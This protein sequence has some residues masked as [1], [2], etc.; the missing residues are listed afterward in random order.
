MTNMNIAEQIG[1]PALLEQAAEE[2]AELVVACLKLSRKMRNENPTPKPMEECVSNLCEEI[3]DV[4]LCVDTLISEID[5]VDA[6][7]V[8]SIMMKKNMRWQKRMV[9]HLL[10]KDGGGCE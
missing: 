2:C 5:E 3:A 4:R 1:V 7:E 10:E 8:L 9:E 6:D